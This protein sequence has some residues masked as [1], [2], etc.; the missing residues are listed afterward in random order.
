MRTSNNHKST[1]NRASGVKRTHDTTR[2]LSGLWAMEVKLQLTSSCGPSTNWSNRVSLSLFKPVNSAKAIPAEWGTI[3]TSLLFGASLIRVTLHRHSKSPQVLG[4]CVSGNIASRWI[5]ML[6]EIWRADITKSFKDCWTVNWV[7]RG[8][9]VVRYRHQVIIC[10][11]ILA[12]S[13]SRSI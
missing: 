12:S 1:S 4:R 9:P 10:I 3:A 6:V 7:P 11:S 8:E 13:S 2:L 5:E